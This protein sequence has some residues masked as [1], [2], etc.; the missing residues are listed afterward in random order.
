M[1]LISALTGIEAAVVISEI[2]EIPVEVGRSYVFDYPAAFVGH[3]DYTMHA[4][5]MVEVIRPLTVDE[6]EPPNH[7]EGITQMYRVRAADGWEGD[8]WDEELRR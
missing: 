3:P 8:A 4:G 2:P 1:R 7:E 6:A 5:Q